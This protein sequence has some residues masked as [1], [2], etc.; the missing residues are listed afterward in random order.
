MA[1]NIIFGL[2]HISQSFSN[3]SEFFDDVTL[4][5]QISTLNYQL[6]CQIIVSITV[7]FEMLFASLPAILYRMEIKKWSKV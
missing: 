6:F 5:K 4:Q 2:N 1:N 7:F 3:W